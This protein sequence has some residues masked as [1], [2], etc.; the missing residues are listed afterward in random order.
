MPNF[1]NTVVGCDVHTWLYNAVVSCNKFD[2]T[3]PLLFV[4]II[5][6]LTLQHSSWLWYKYL[7]L[8]DIGWYN[9]VVDYDT[10]T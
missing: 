7:T 2:F 3:A 10:N 9:T 6:A 5:N 8:Q 1:Y 4:I